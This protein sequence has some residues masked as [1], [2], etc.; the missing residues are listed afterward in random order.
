MSKIIDDDFS[1]LFDEIGG[2]SD[3]T[4][5]LKN[6]LKVDS[7]NCDSDFFFKYFFT[8]HDSIL[9]QEKKFIYLLR[10]TNQQFHVVHGYSKNGKSTFIRNTIR[11]FNSHEFEE[12]EGFNFKSIQSIYYDYQDLGA[13]D[14][15]EKIK[16]QISNTFLCNNTHFQREKN[17]SLVDFCSVLNKFK[18]FLN[19]DVIYTPELNLINKYTDEV[20]LKLTEFERKSRAVLNTGDILLVRN[21]FNITI[22]K[23]I[24]IEN[25]DRYFVFKVLYDISQILKNNIYQ[26]HP[27]KIV[28]IL[29]N[30]DEYLRN[31]DFEYLKH[32]Q[33]NI[34]TFFS[35]LTLK[36]RISVFFIKSVIEIYSQPNSENGI[37]PFN[38][39]SQLC[40]VYV[41]RTA[42]FLAFA[43]LMKD[44]F[45]KASTPG[46]AYLPDGMLRNNYIRYSTI[47]FTDK[48][49]V[50]RL[51][52]YFELCQHLGAQP[53]K[54]YKFLRA[55]AIQFNYDKEDDSI[56]K[57]YRNIFN[58]WNGDKVMLFTYIND[59]WDFISNKYFLYEN[60]IEDVSS[61]D[62][63]YSTYIIKGV[64]IHLFL[65]LFE[66]NEN[67]RTLLTHILYSFNDEIDE[68]RGKNIRRLILNIVINE[69]EK[70]KRIYTQDND[71]SISKILEKGIGLY[72]LLS[73]IQDYIRKFETIPGH[74]SK[75][76][77][78]NF[79]KDICDT[80]KIDFFA[81]LISIYKN[82]ISKEELN[83][84]SYTNFYNLNKEISR[85]YTE[86][87]KSKD[88]LNKIRVFNNNNAAYITSSLLS[89]F[90]Y[91]S[92]IQKK[93]NKP[94]VI[95]VNRI[96]NLKIA[97]KIEQ[98]EFYDI[99]EDVVKCAT[100]TINIMVN[101][102]I[103][104]I[105]DFYVPST[106]VRSNLFSVLMDYNKKDMPVN[107]SLYIG[108][109]HFRMIVARHFTY[110]ECFRQ[111]ILS[112]QNI[113][114]LADAEKKMVNGYLLSV[115]KRYN[116][117][118]LEKYEDI[119]SKLTTKEG[120]RDNLGVR[121]L[122]KDYK[123]RKF[124]S[125]KFNN[126]TT[127]KLSEYEKFEITDE[128]L[129][130]Y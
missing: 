124:Y 39:Q 41:F 82:Q 105:I 119:L 38:F 50:Q 4:Y 55:M 44:I 40:F 33:V 104:N 32:P 87:D 66:K 101:F 10:S 11:K 130:D 107:E 36:H 64:Y 114:K 8:S 93:N 79:F 1:K 35:T 111:A 70:Q 78:V 109:F 117:L 65:D 26:S 51:N 48:I 6:I 29:D 96:D 21:L 5:V 67:F 97:D 118:Y 90:E 72:D 19:S 49:I 42:N 16:E 85:F 94:L 47:Q 46:E 53:P 2:K 74:Y 127:G 17:I 86:G 106:F 56:H 110:I 24:N 108:N 34:F 45:L 120:K 13:G 73:Q 20:I 116:S 22:T 37:Y 99:I 128:Q 102:Y 54:G 123:I 129:L 95:S 103:K 112:P 121:N 62:S 71:N 98:F 60:C 43:H 28:V 84:T 69:S 9:E 77:V 31:N 83:N 88:D 7:L 92:F 25:V 63:K 113:Y 15:I 115:L 91:F 61:L 52:R 3:L 80:T 81:Q 18:D 27:D 58:L 75:T 59:N 23:D 89:N 68:N 14:F 126:I 100:N 122:D 30:I 12:V 76:D 57:K 125:E